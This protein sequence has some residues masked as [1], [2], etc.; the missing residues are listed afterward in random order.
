MKLGMEGWVSYVRLILIVHWASVFQSVKW[1][2]MPR[3]IRTWTYET[4]NEK[5]QDFGRVCENRTS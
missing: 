1:K 3:D 2:D 4:L 5:E